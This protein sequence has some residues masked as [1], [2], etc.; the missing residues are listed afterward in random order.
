M[1]ISDQQEL[2]VKANFNV[3]KLLWIY[4]LIWYMKQT[5]FITHKGILKDKA[6]EKKDIY[7]PNDD[8]QKTPSRN[9]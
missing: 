8:K 2:F 9:I 7:I 5:V 6:I 1:V 3:L 4:M